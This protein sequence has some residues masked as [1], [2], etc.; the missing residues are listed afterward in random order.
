MNDATSAGADSRADRAGNAVRPAPTTEV[1][2]V[3]LGQGLDD[4]V[5]DFLLARDVGVV[6]GALAAL[7][8]GEGGLEI[9]RLFRLRFRS[10][11]AH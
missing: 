2:S 9:G 5:V 4:A 8:L 7:R 1:R 11:P 6:L 3:V 10:W